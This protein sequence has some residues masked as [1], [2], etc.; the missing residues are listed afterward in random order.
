MTN[1]SQTDTQT[2]P[3]EI[4][5]LEAENVTVADEPG[6]IN[7]AMA[8]MLNAH[9]PSVTV[10]SDEPEAEGLPSD[11]SEAGED[12]TLE[13]T[14]EV[15]DL[16]EAAP[17][18]EPG[19][20]TEAVAEIPAGDISVTEAIEALPSALEAPEADPAKLPMV[21]IPYAVSLLA[22]DL[23]RAYQQNLPLD[24]VTSTCISPKRDENRKVYFRVELIAYR[25]GQPVLDVERATRVIETVME[26]EAYQNYDV[27]AGKFN[28]AR[29]SVRVQSKAVMG[30]ETALIENVPVSQAPEAPKPVAA[31][32][33]EVQTETTVPAPQ[34]V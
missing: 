18:L 30:S 9:M 31:P 25:R 23:R 27:Q 33:A 15:L 16:L 34:T 29:I 26:Q 32:V 24:H 3:A 1:A 13:P 7:V 14:T 10:T 21:K 12:V 8:S 4:Q 2:I 19:Q 28:P 20:P 5:A 6:D 17:E 11:A 22:S